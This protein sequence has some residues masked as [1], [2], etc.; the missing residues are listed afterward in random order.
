VDVLELVERLHPTPAVCGWPTDAALRVIESHERFER[1]WY[2]GPLGWIDGAGDG[3][4]AVALRSALVRGERGWLFAGAGI[5]GD[6]RPEDELAEIELKLA[7]LAGALEN[8][9][10]R[11]R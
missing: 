6:S 1:G 3:E 9:A 11:E 10:A 2:A 7:P 5:M 8:G 4:F